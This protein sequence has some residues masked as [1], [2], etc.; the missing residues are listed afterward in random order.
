MAQV[1]GVLVIGIVV[2]AFAVW[3]IDRGVLRRRLANA[4]K[5]VDQAT[6]G[7]REVERESARQERAQDRILDAMEEGVLLLDASGTRLYAN[8]ALSDLLGGAPDRAT[9]VGGAREAVDGSL[10][11]TPRAHAPLVRKPAE[12][13]VVSF[14]PPA[15]F[16]V[17]APVEGRATRKSWNAAKPAGWSFSTS[18]AFNFFEL[19]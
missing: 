6:A 8:R 2:G 4:Q 14:A 5:R 3:A 16:N 18:V 17:T 15:L 13:A 11:L 9:A 1:A 12:N 7:R 19:S 10:A